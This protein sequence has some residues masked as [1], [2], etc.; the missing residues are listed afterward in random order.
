MEILKQEVRL[1]NT[2]LTWQ[3]R[4]GGR[5]LKQAL[6]EELQAIKP[7]VHLIIN[8]DQ[9]GSVVLTRKERNSDKNLEG[10][11]NALKTHSATNPFCLIEVSDYERWSRI[12][13]HS[14][15]TV[16][17]WRGDQCKLVGRRIPE[18]ND[19]ARLEHR[20]FF[21]LVSSHQVLWVQDFKQL[22]VDEV[23]VVE[24]L[25]QLVDVGLVVPVLPSDWTLA[26]TNML[27][28]MFKGEKALD[29]KE[30]ERLFGVEMLERVLGK[31]ELRN[32]NQ[33]YWY[34]NKR[35]RQTIGFA[36]VRP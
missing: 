17:S 11:L 35:I 24:R 25:A 30:M 8:C 20:V 6:S 4:P 27:L 34:R 21:E 12:T 15:M 9:V 33:H 32:P 23:Q 14:Q 7:G 28:Y 1:I 26:E 10:L 16:V 19:P 5:P 2:I 29:M 3:S 13:S 31:L 36:V 22:G 18:L